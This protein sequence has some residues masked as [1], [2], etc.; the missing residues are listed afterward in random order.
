MYGYNMHVYMG[1]LYIL[2]ISVYIYAHI[3]ACIC[4]YVH[5]FLLPQLVPLPHFSALIPPNQHI[6]H[7]VSSSS[8]S[9]ATSP[10]EKA[11]LS[12]SQ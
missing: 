6:A 10:K 3:H 1:T 5:T 12:M 11:F 9:L 4:V 7:E 8:C 2:R